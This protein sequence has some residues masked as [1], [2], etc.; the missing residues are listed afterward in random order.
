MPKQY[1]ANKK[2]SSFKGRRTVGSNK[3]KYV[4]SEASETS[5]STVSSISSNT[6]SENN[7][8]EIMRGILNTDS[9]PLHTVNNMQSNMSAMSPMMQQLQQPMMQPNMMQPNM[10][11]MNIMNSLKNLSKL[12]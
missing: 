7:T 5:Q 1:K 4:A 8:T 2:N 9:E 3:S 12:S 6:R 11:D 10:M